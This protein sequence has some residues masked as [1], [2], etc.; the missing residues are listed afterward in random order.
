MKKLASK[1]E[2]SN[3]S[4]ILLAPLPQ[5]PSFT[6]ELCSS[7]WFRPLINKNCH[8]TNKDF[9]EKQRD[10]IVKAITVLA[11]EVNN[12]YILDPFN[13]FCDKKYCYVKKDNTYLFSDDDHLSKEGAIMISKELLSL[14]NSIN[15]RESNPKI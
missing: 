6:P 5:H 13:R 11:R 1:L 9:L 12:I 10:H 4:L 2:D 3:A 14:I 7:Q 15:S 8:K